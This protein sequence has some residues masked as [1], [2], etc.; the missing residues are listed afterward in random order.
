MVDY[1]IISS[2]DHVMEPPDLWTERIEPKYRDRAPRV[3]R[4]EDGGDWWFCDGVRGTTAAAGSQVGKR[5]DDPANLTRAK[6]YESVRLGA[7]IP[8]EHVKDMDLDGID[9]SIIYA[10]EGQ[11]LYNVPDSDLLSAAFRAYNDWLADFCR[12]FPH[13]I[14]G[15]ALLNVDDVGEG[16]REL[17]RCVG[18]GLLGAMITVYPPAGRSYDLPEYEPLW[19][20]AQDL[21]M[22][23]SLHVST[24]RVRPSR[25]RGR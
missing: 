24:N 9:V 23:L 2:D 18:L 17:E 25:H 11:F 4:D 13:R 15:I 5:F 16:I 22:P 10:T 3:V 19:A 6:T 1:R 14:K 21:E 8:E 20:A 7:Y 12:P